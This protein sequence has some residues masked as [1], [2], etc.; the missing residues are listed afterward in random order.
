[1]VTKFIQTKNNIL[2]MDIQP[3]PKQIITLDNGF[4]LEIRALAVVKAELSLVTG[5]LKLSSEEPFTI[6]D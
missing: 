1:M 2:K 6:Y 5:E 4:V 3:G